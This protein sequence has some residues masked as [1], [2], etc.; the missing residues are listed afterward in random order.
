MKCPSCQSEVSEDSRFCSK[1]GSA[2][3][4]AAEG[5]VSFTKTLTTP[6]PGLAL[7]SLLAGKYRIREEIGHGGMGI[8]YRAEDIKLGR[9]VALKFLPPGWTQD[10][11]ARERFIQEAR[12]AAALSHPNVCTVYEVDDSGEH[13]FIAM[14]Y[15]TGET[16]REKTRRG[17]LPL[18]EALDVASQAAEGLEAAHRQGVIHRDI[19]SANIMVTDKGQAKVMDFGLAKLRGGSSLTGEGATLGTVAYMSPE[20]ARGE[21]VDHRTD[22]WSLGVVLYEML[23][24]ELPFRGERDVSLLYSI[25]HEEPRFLGDKKPPVPPDLQRVLERALDKKAGS[26]Y[27]TAAE[28]REDIVKYQDVL[29]A[30]AAGIFNVHNL[31]KSLRRPAVIVP[32]LI[33]LIAV[34][35]LA[36]WLFNRQAK[37]RWASRVALPEIQRLIDS[38]FQNWVPAYDLAVRAK[39]QIPKDPKLAELF[40]KCSG[41][42]DIVT[43]PPGA[44]VSI[45]PYGSPDTEWSLVGTAPIKEERVP[46][47][48]FQFRIEREGYA[49]I[50]CVKITVGFDIKTGR[51]AHATPIKVTLD[52]A[53]SLPPGMIR[54]PG[55]DKIGDFF[56]DQFEV[57][58]KQYKE[59]VDKGGYRNRAFWKQ[60][61]IKDGKELGREEAV[62]GFVDQTGRPGPSTWAAGEYKKGQED[63]PVAG[64]S[65]YEAAAYAEF[66]GK[67]LPT[68]DHWAAATGINLFTRTIIHSLLPLSNF[69]G[70]GPAAVGSH[71]GMVMSGAHDMAGN[72]RE[73]CW[74]ETRQGRAIR[75][76]AWNDA[77][78]MFLGVTQAPPFDRSARNGFRCVRYIDPEKIPATTFAPTELTTRRDFYQEKPVADDIFRVYKE[79]FFYDPHELKAVVEKKEESPEWIAEKVSF[80]ASYA[81]E[82][83]IAWLFLPRTGPPPYQTVIFFPGSDAT[84]YDSS[85]IIQGSRYR[86]YFDFIVANGRAVL[87]PIYKG[88]FERKKGFEDSSSLHTG[89]ETRRYN[90]YL[91]QVVKDFKR[92]VDYSESRKD[93]DGKKL[94]FLGYSW[95]GQMGD[96]IP[97]VEDRLKASVLVVGGLTWDVRPRPEAD[98]INYVTRVKVPTLMLNGRYDIS[99]FPFE[100]AVKPMYDLLGTPKEDKRLALFETD[101]FIPRNDTVRETL[102]WLDKYLGPVR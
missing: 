4:A 49:P 54:V 46:W 23:S 78:Y 84:W 32:G 71:P 15:V 36:F 51:Y 55:A 87:W 35:S 52:K 48:F 70:E 6:R 12:A 66:S 85:E 16:L 89:D 81:N 3:H 75:G 68:V 39:K 53:E 11:R 13:P 60:K 38:G 62:A 98:E 28:M 93:I 26:R 82:R 24:G 27:Q 21:K 69:G 86:A 88:T 79:Q 83:M 64:V 59:F 34:A 1:C 14:E 5:E 91:I 42:V 57:T 58:N 47:G 92:S 18:E 94:A 44:S 77:I 96:L 25:V 40:S 80:D 63:F 97:A 20:Q 95:G 45:K 10:E 17:P 41:N 9:P 61:F 7:G 31:F 90:D 22:I 101:H 73:W 100:I 50:L 8:V 33:G 29:K 43:D 99:A 74:N 72:V 19:K 67:S 65:W 76:G 56:I 2:V 37:I 30:E 102:A